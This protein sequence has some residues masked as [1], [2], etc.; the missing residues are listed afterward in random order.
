MDH[1]NFVIDAYNQRPEVVSRMPDLHF[2]HGPA[3]AAGIGFG[4]HAINVGFMI[5][6]GSVSSTISDSLGNIETNELILK[7]SAI[8]IEFAQFPE[9]GAAVAF[10][11]GFSAEY[12]PVRLIMN[13]TSQPNSLLDRFDLLS[14]T[15]SAQLYIGLADNIFIWLKP[16]F[17][18]YAIRADLTRTYTLMV[19]NV[20][21]DPSTDM[22]GKFDNFGIMTGLMFSFGE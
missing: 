8:M 14:A 4:N 12:A 15:P 11:F 20:N 22:L 18:F 7:S 13:S 19:P 6:N 17:Q 5:G 2:I 21:I 1:L 10:S 9:P 16:Y 3:G